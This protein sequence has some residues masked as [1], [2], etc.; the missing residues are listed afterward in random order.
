MTIKG[1]YAFYNEKKGNTLITDKALL[2]QRI[3]KDTLFL[4]ADSL[5]AIFDSTRTGKLLYAYN[6]AK[7]FKNDLQG[8]GDSL[9]YS[10][11]DSTIL[12]YQNPVLWTDKNQLTGDTIEILMRNNQI[13]RLNLYS[14][15]FVISQDDSLR[16]NQV[17]GKNL[18]GFFADNEL[19]RIDVNGNG[20]TVYYIRDSDQALIGVN[21]A[22]SDNL[23]IY[24]EKNEIQTITFISRPE[25]TLYPEKDLSS[26]DTILKNFR[27][28]NDKRP[29]DR[30]DIFNW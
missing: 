18:S 22:K 21:I 12:M 13:Y 9:V 20:E 29:Y 28:E 14:S 8:L 2:M 1:N 11:K 19:R 26:K 24:V 15:A 4:H 27:W 17:K 3:D 6:K 23:K 5:R 30:Y 16:F 25:A 7:F 10:F